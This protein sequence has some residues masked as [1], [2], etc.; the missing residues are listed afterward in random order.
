MELDRATVDRIAYSGKVP[1]NVGGVTPGQY[2][3]ASPGPGDTIIGVPVT[4]PDLTQ[5]RHAV[6]RVNRVLDDGRAEVAVIVH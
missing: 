1:C 5:Y 6:G 2:I 3:V 4:D